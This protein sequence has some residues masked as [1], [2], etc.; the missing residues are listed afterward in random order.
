MSP[1][2]PAPARPLLFGLLVAFG[3]GAGSATAAPAP[4]APLPD[5]LRPAAPRPSVSLIGEWRLLGPVSRAPLIWMMDFTFQREEPT[6][7]Q[8]EAVGLTV[9]LQE[10]VG[11]TRRQWKEHPEDPELQSMKKSW[12]ELKD[13]GVTI[14][15]SSIQSRYGDATDK[16][17]YKL[18]SESGNQVRVRASKAGAPDQEL[19]FILT[20]A[21]TA[22]MGPVGEEPIVLQRKK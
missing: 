18:I 19:L 9:D 22:L 7:S 1:T 8:M 11:D 21:Q 16:L 20:D 4:A 5:V 13:L 17:S 10:R 2:L 12:E 6:V 3:L 15:S 14:T